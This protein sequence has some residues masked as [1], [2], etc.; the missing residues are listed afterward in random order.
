MITNIRRFKRFYAGQRVYVS[1]NLLVYYEEGNPKRSFAPDSFVVK[2]CDPRRRRIFKIWE[3]G[4]VPHFILETTSSSTRREDQGKKKKLCEELKVPE[5]FLYDPLGDWLKPALQG[6]R[7]GKRG[8]APIA[9]DAEGGI[10]SQ[11][12]GI[13]FQLENGQ[14]AMFDLATGRRL[15]CD[16]EEAAAATEREAAATLRAADVEERLAR[17]I[18]ARQAL[19]QELGR[20][21]RA[22]G[23]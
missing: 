14:L 17:E 20:L 9:P 8:Y 21:R 13:R 1:G 7:L 11:Q 16:A 19:E 4:K 10:T 6:Y 22:K 15:L 12:R 18:A 2:D 3:E 5:Y 23:K